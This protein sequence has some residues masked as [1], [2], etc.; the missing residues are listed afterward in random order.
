MENAASCALTVGV[1][2]GGTK[3]AAGLVDG[4][5]VILRRVVRPTPSTSPADVEDV[6]AGCVEELG[7]GVQVS[8][9]GIGA[10]GF[11][12][13]DGAT[14]VTSPNLAWRN[15]PLR[16]RVAA[17]L[18]VAVTVD[19]DANAAA[20]G[21]F[22]FG[23]GR[24]GDDLIMVTVGTGIGGGIVL[25][26]RL[27]RGAHGLAAEIGHLRAVEGGRACGCGL[28]GCWEQY[29]SGPAL[30]RTAGRVARVPV[31]G[32][33]LRELAGGSVPQLTSSMV[34]QAAAEGDAGAQECFA[35]V[36]QW[37]GKGLADLAAIFDPAVFV[38]G[39]GVADCGELLLAPAR[40][41]FA[42][43][44]TAGAARTHPKIVPAVLGN[45]AGLV[46]AADLARS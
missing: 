43:R 7:E 5:G 12:S 22:R 11:V 27:F 25:S 41:A 31:L 15:E 36:G 39:G 23:A 29:C 32:R 24:G 37:L 3:V 21:E 45:D 20:W 19:N 44:L 6:I 18:G 34:A 9:V 38:I 14:V 13:A 46:G 30:L 4:D 33:R 8:A 17:R 42:E 28:V 1:D 35:D 40:A 2:I 26:G 10:A 16:D